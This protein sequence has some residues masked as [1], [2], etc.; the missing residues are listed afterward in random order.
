MQ[1]DLPLDEIVTVVKISVHDKK[2]SVFTGKTVSGKDFLTS[3]MIWHAGRNSYQNQYQS[4][5][6][7]SRLEN[8]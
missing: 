2:I 3:G 7:K 1:V 8:I 5:N 4:T 6:Q